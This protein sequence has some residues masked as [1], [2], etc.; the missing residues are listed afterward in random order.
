MEAVSCGAIL[1]NYQRLRV[2][3]VCGRYY[4]IFCYIYFLFLLLL[5][6]GLL[7]R[8]GLISLAYLW[9]Q[10]Q[11]ELLQSMIS[12]TYLIFFYQYTICISLYFII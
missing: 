8:L 7:I 9:H 5:I 11:M 6:F 4:F 1:S 10:D 3:N 2:E 12:D